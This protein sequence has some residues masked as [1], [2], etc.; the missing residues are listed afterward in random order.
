[1]RQLPDKKSLGLVFQDHASAARVLVQSGWCS[2]VLQHVQ[3]P[4]LRLQ[5][6][7]G[8]VERRYGGVWK[9]ARE[10]Q[11]QGEGLKGVPNHK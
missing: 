5:P 2:R 4:L 6:H 7:D 3:R 10:G 9:A 8:L 11:R 1:M